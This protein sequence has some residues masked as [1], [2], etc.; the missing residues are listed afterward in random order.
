MRTNKKRSFIDVFNPMIKELGSAT[1]AELSSFYAGDGFEAFR[2]YIYNPSGTSEAVA[3]MLA[4]QGTTSVIWNI[5]SENERE[6]VAYFT[7][8][9]NVLPYYDGIEDDDFSLS[10]YPAISVADVKMFAVSEKYQDVFCKENSTELPVA[11]KCLQL[12]IG[13]INNLSYNNISIQAIYLHSIP[14]AEKFY[15][16]NG[17]LYIPSSATPLF[18]VDKGNKEMWLPIRKVLLENDDE[19]SG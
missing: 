7:L 14:T 16:N 15:L 2:D 19:K 18:S 13:Y 10:N 3:D 12:V 17:F 9:A 1:S 5:K 4:G 8:A 6:L 11:A